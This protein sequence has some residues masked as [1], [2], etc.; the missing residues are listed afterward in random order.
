MSEARKLFYD[1]DYIAQLLIL[2]GKETEISI[3]LMNKIEEDNYGERKSIML[4]PEEDMSINLYEEHLNEKDAHRKH[5]KGNRLRHVHRSGIGE[6]RSCRNNGWFR[7]WHTEETNRNERNNRQHMKLMLAKLDSDMI[8]QEEAIISSQTVDCV[9]PVYEA[10][11]V[12]AL[13]NGDMNPY[14]WHKYRQKMLEYGWERPEIPDN[15]WH[16]KEKKWY[17]YIPHDYI[18]HNATEDDSIRLSEASCVSA[19]E[20]GYWLIKPVTYRSHT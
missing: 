15:A 4:F 1:G 10:F 3:S 2:P 11:E 19:K 9:A 13:E 7:N 5:R 6:F 20:R 16:Y 14:T 12:Q 17:Y 18:P 8:R